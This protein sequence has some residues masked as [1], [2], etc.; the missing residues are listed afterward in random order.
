M[1]I[2]LALLALLGVAVLP[3]FAGD[4]GKDLAPA[5]ASRNQGLNSLGGLLQA[6]YFFH[7]TRRPLPL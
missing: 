7:Y 5:L 6:S 4:T 3:T 1:K 2:R